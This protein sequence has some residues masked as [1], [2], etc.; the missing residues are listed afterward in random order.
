MGDILILI[1]ILR[2]LTFQRLKFDAQTLIQ[3]SDFESFGFSES[4]RTPA[5]P[6]G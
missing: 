4:K 6:S 5:T 1:A 2:A 3:V